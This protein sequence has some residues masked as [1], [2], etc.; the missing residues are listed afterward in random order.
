M[1]IPSNSLISKGSEEPSE[2]ERNKEPGTFDSSEFTSFLE[3]V[4][5]DY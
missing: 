3:F 2:I 5:S 4:G 1:E